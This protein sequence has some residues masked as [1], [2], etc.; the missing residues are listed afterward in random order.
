MAG[1]DCSAGFAI[2]PIIMIVFFLSILSRALRGAGGYSGGYRSYRRPGMFYALQYL[3]NRR[4]GGHNPRG[5][6]QWPRSP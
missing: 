1:E 6:T 3:D 2:F 5:G 4:G